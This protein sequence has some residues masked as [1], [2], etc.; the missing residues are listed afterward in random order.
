[1]DY[2]DI[3]RIADSLLT[4]RD[5]YRSDWEINARMV[6][7]AGYEHLLSS[8]A[9]GS[10]NSAVKYSHT[11]SDACLTLAS[12]HSHL[13]TPSNAQW[14]EMRAPH[15]GTSKES[16]T[17]MRFAS[18]ASTSLW[19]AFS[20][21]NFQAAMQEAYIDRCGISHGAVHARI[22][23][24]DGSFVF[25]HIPAGTFAIAKDDKGMCNTFIREFDMTAMQAAQRFGVDALGEKLR[26]DY[27]EPRNASVKLHRFYHVVLPNPKGQAGFFKRESKERKFFE[28][29]LCED[30]KKIVMEE[31]LFEFPFFLTVF[32][33]W[34]SS[35]YGV[36][37]A[38]L[39]RTP[40]KRLEGLEHIMDGLAQKALN[41]PLVI[42]EGQTGVVDMRP[43]GITPIKDEYLGS[44]MPR[45]L[46][47][48]GRYDVGLDRV[49][50][51]REIVKTAYFYEIVKPLA[52][53]SHQM[54]AEE[55]RRRI[56]ENTLN[57]VHSFSQVSNDLTP[58][59]QACFSMLYRWS[60]T[61]DRL[62]DDGVLP[63]IPTELEGKFI[64][65]SADERDFYFSKMDIVFTSR[66]AIALKE[67]SN[68]QNMQ[69]V[70]YVGNLAMSLQ[71]PQLLD[72]IDLDAA[73]RNHLKDNNASTSIIQTI[74]K[75]DEIREQRAEAQQMQ[76]E[77]EQAQQ[78]AK[79]VKD[80]SG[81]QQ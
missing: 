72:N 79:A 71:M 61:S 20:K 33:K 36:A 26:K 10:A 37:P 56:N 53:L 12:A 66:I 51:L 63:R 34:G 39:C 5:L 35:P 73:V 41:P 50:E 3:M 14:F 24:E 18:E 4:Q 68:Q 43:K 59:I 54:T 47:P 32:L 74:S 38:Q 55:V 75:R 8:Q 19:S 1:M 80:I 21:S 31:G 15:N 7:P 46:A 2:V 48:Q 60:L 65:K 29:F 13:V 49:R 25:T 52:G 27:D 45:E 23:A 62:G 22:D 78:A 58:F 77:M 42:T 76:A 17:V 16:D 44:G 6:H 67:V 9:K 30:D 64:I 69:G 81:I 70:E 40:I 28:Y 11:A 57:F